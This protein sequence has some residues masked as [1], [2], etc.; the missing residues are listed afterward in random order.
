MI[1]ELLMKE[2]GPA[3]GCVAEVIEPVTSKRYRE[4]CDWLRDHNAMDAWGEFV[5]VRWLSGTADDGF[6]YR[7][8]FRVV[9]RASAKA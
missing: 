8:G 9:D 2:Y 4:M 5:C 7:R 1:G 6:Y 3:A